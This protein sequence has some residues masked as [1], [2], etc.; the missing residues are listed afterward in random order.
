MSVEHVIGK[1][2]KSDWHTKWDDLAATRLRRDQPLLQDTDLRSYGLAQ[3]TFRGIPEL[4]AAS[5]LVEGKATVL[6]LW[7]IVKAEALS[8]ALVSHIELGGS[9]FTEVCLLSGESI[10][11]VT[12]LIA[13]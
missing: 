9:R 7:E 8:E 4:I 12:N 6:D 10:L 2:E 5:L 3:H 1:L 11:R 13:D